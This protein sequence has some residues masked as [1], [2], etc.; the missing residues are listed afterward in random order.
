MKQK[1]AMQI[2]LDSINKELESNAIKDIEYYGGLE[3]VKDYILENFLLE[4]E[5]EQIMDARNDALKE[6]YTSVYNDLI[7]Y[8]QVKIETKTSEQY[9]NETYLKENK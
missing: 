8:G 5:K 2:L 9:Y 4:K 6:K 7:T 1:T 3:D